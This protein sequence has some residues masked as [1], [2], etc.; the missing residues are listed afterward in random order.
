MY[1]EE[2]PLF[3]SP[4]NNDNHDCIICGDTACPV[5]GHPFLIAMRENANLLFVSH[6][7]SQIIMND[8]LSLG[9]SSS[10]ALFVTMCVAQPFLGAILSALRDKRCCDRATRATHWPSR[11]GR[12]IYLVSLCMAL[13]F[14]GFVVHSE[15]DEYPLIAFVLLFI[16]AIDHFAIVMFTVGM[17]KD[18]DRAFSALL[19]Y[20]FSAKLQDEACRR[21]AA[22]N[23]YFLSF[24]ESTG[25]SAEQRTA[26]RTTL[27]LD[28]WIRR[29]H[30]GYPHEVTMSELGCC[31]SAMIDLVLG[32]SAVAIAL[33]NFLLVQIAMLLLMI[34]DDPEMSADPKWFSSLSDFKKIQIVV[35][36]LWTLCEGIQ[37]RN[38]LLNLRTHWRSRTKC[39]TP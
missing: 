12:F 28:Y 19:S 23:Y 27:D 38:D 4:F 22:V 10:F 39:P 37:I 1:L 7:I 20:I 3:P 18:T 8:Q 31:E 33:Y 11:A 36:M 14:M 9:I 26:I 17:L 21:M 24:V 34:F 32:I 13:S 2:I 15:H 30:S 25:E 5:I 35:W 29:I 16:V 6:L